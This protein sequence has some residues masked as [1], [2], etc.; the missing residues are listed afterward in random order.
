MIG[1]IFY[2]DF[3]KIEEKKPR[4]EELGGGE[5]KRSESYGKKTVS[6]RDG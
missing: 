1:L 3:N 2:E 6:N 5:K 4:G